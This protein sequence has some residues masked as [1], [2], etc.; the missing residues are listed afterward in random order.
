MTHWDPSSK[1]GPQVGLFQQAEKNICGESPLVGLEVAINL[2]NDPRRK[3][4]I[5]QG[6]LV[7][8]KQ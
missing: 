8:A 2:E 4:Q 5:L 1:L 3:F 7:T 6:N